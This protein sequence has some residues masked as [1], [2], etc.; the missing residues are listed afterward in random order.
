MKRFYWRIAVYWAVVLFIL[1]RT[2]AIAEIDLPLLLKDD[3]E[4]GMDRWQ[5]TDPNPAKWRVENY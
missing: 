4:Q 5:T 1:G 3:F 2:E